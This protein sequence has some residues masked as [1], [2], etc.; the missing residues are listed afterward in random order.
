MALEAEVKFIDRG[1]LPAQFWLPPLFA[2]K[3]TK[4]MLQ[5]SSDGPS[6]LLKEVYF[7]GHGGFG[8]T[9]L[10]VRDFGGAM[11]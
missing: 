3:A 10:A 1:D 6:T 5:C 9:G 8:Y 7:F 11:S 2:A 4:S